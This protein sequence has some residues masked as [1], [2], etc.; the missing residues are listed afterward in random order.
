MAKNLLKG[1]A[2]LAICAAFAS[3]SH[4]TDFTAANKSA[5]VENLKNEYKADFIKKYGEID[6]NQSWDFTNTSSKATRASSDYTIDFEWPIQLY[7]TYAGNDKAYMENLNYNKTQDNTGYKSWNPN[8]KVQLWPSYGR[9]TPDADVNINYSFYHLGVVYN[10]VEEDITNK[11]NA[12]YNTWYEVSGYNTLNHNSGRTVDTK[13]AAGL[14]WVAYPTASDNS[15]GKTFNSNMNAI[16]TTPGNKYVITDYKEVKVPN[17]TRTY[18]C[19]DCNADGIYSDVICLVIDADPLPIQ[20]RYM[21][22][23]LGSKGDFDFNDIVVDVIQD[24]N[25]NQTATI[26]AMGGTLD[27][28]VKIGQTTWTKSVE[29][30]D[31]GYV[32]ETMYNTE[33][34]PIWNAELATFSVTGWIPSS[35]NIVVSVKHKINDQTVE[36]KGEDVIIEIP[37]TKD[38]DVPMI[39]AVVPP[40]CDWQLERESLPQ[41]WWKEPENQPT[42]Q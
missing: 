32:V 30:A 1:M 19:F 3:C 23:D 8:L 41:N 38:G 2:A 29:G 42:A 15:A 14:Y 27:F 33:P 35:N 13:S 37:F 11:I 12:K 5:Y 6:P 17:T 31:K 18:W 36:K 20:K 21:I 34:T 4:D 28:T 16:L 22:E 40:L 7:R 25:N 26:R 39:I 24:K 9:A 10:G